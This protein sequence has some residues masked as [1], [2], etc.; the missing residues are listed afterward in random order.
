MVQL[1]PK[2]AV[3]CEITRND[4]KITQGHR[5]WY[6]SKAHMPLSASEIIPTYAPTASELS[7]RIGQSIAFD[8]GDSIRLTVWR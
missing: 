6:Q 3:L 5:F 2:D 4:V 7:W 1:A 8:G